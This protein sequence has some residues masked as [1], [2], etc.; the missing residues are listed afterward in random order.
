MAYIQKP[1][2]FA[3]YETWSGVLPVGS[4]AHKD[5]E[6][7]S[8][9]RRRINAK[10]ASLFVCKNLII[11]VWNVRSIREDQVWLFG[12][13]YDVSAMSQ[14]ED[15]QVNLKSP[16]PNT[17]APCNYTVLYGEVYM[18]NE[19]L[20]T[21]WWRSLLIKVLDVN[22]K[23]KVDFRKFFYYYKNSET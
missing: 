19:T 5:W 15:E 11:F 6:V 14:C 12:C 13:G 22:N 2:P 4:D 17:L 10:E 7:R 23:R 20:G 1:L 21:V 18:Q 3:L 9:T 8:E 16:H